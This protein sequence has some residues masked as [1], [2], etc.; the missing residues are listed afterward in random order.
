MYKKIAILG[1]FMAA[2]IQCFAISSDEM[3]AKLIKKYPEVNFVGVK[4]TPVSNIFEIQIDKK[5]IM[6]AEET[7]EYFFP[8]MVELKTKRNLGQERIDELSK[9]N[10]KSLPLKDAIK[11]VKGNGKRVMAVFSDIDCPYCKQLEG[12]LTAL[13]DVTIY[14]FEFPLSIHP[15]A[16]EKSI[17]IWCSK[18][19]SEQWTKAIISGVAPK[20]LDCENPI[21]RNISLAKKLEIYGTPAMIFADGSILPGAASIEVIEEK[22][23]RGAK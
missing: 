1:L 9:I 23:N 8:T 18:N 5:T 3:K 4:S 13:D 11:T 16:R 6:F 14:T 21:D 10:F 15:G 22:L 17:S 12:T 7:G 2:S 20:P 19:P